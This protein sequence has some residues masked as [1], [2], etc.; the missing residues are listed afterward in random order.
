LGLWAQGHVRDI[1]KAQEK[2]DQKKS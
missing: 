1:H 2:F